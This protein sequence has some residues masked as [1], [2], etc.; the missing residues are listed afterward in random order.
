MTSSE[1]ARARRMAKYGLT[2]EKYEDILAAQNGVCKICG[3]PPKKQRL[4]VDHDHALEK[5]GLMFVRGLLCAMC[6]HKILGV[7]E[8]YRVDPQKI[9]DYLQAASRNAAAH[10]AVSVGNLS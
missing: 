10:L 3:R 9:V 2:I 4:N 5:K 6:N 1:K 8:R 7:I